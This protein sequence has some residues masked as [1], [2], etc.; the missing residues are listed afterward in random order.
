ML[1]GHVGRRR[2][3]AR[4]FAS[5][6]LTVSRAAPWL[7]LATTVENS[8]ASG[9]RVRKSFMA[10]DAFKRLA[11]VMLSSLAMTGCPGAVQ[12]DTMLQTRVAVP[13][14]VCR[15]KLAP[16]ANGQGNQVRDLDA[17]QWVG[18]VVPEFAP[19]KGL[20]PTAVDCTG[21]YVF[22]NESLRGGAT[23][24]NW[25]LGVDPDDVAVQAGPNG[26]RTVWVRS[27]RFDNGDEGG[28]LAL[29]RAAGDS[30]DVFAVGSFRGPSDS[31]IT[32]ARLGN[33]AIVVAETKD[34]PPDG[35]DCRKRLFFYLPRRGRLIQG[36]VIDLE[37]TSVVPS[38]TEKGLFTQYKLSTDVTY[39]PEGI[40]LLE[41]LQ[42]RTTKTDVPDL[43]S[44]RHLRTVE[45]S[46]LLKVERDSMFSTNDA[47]WDRVVGRD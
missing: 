9:V 37:R 13:V 34:C 24:R 19:E 1:R 28:P 38:V 8:L 35:K 45:F 17:E 12:Q 26:M 3:E 29:T 10:I 39:K 30:A 11:P 7:V 41:Q 32:P 40:L 27:I 23:P 44:D 43:D 16:A 47:L 22:A 21:N 5:P 20:E 33:E 36:A 6:R 31:K 46:R 15:T 2:P 4:A 14:A 18:V 25:P 42:V